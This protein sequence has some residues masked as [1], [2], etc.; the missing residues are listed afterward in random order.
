[1]ATTSTCPCRGSSIVGIKTH[2][3]GGLVP[4]SLAQ[5]L[6]AK[7]TG[8]ASHGP[9][10][11]NQLGLLEALQVGGGGAQAEGVKAERPA[12]QQK[13]FKGSPFDVEK[14]GG[15]AKSSWRKGVTNNSCHCI[16]PG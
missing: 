14:L 6:C 12:R 11:V 15:G 13:L 8:H 10:A 7:G 3:E 9:P 5:K 16:V 4:I 2:P 1:M